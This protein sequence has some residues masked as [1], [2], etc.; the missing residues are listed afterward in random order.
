MKS[1]VLFSLFLVSPLQAQTT[2]MEL[3]HNNGDQLTIQRLANGELW[4]SFFLT[5]AMT[6]SFASNELIVVQVD[7]FK[8]L[9]LTQGFR[10]CGAPAPKAQQ[11]VYQFEQQANNAWAF[12]GQQANK[13]SVL[14]LLGWDAA[15]Y[16]QLQADRRPEVVD[17]PLDPGEAL[18]LQLANAGQISFRYV[19]DRGEQ[20]ETVFHL[21]PHRHILEQLLP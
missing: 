13:T 2:A 7:S 8:P 19:T 10:S 1:I 16:E 14:K 5:D 18:A 17:F 12:N 11:V 20:R 15:T 4:G 6:A 21:T 9:K 3:R